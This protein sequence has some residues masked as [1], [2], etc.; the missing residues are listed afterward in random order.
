M[1]MFQSLTVLLSLADCVLAVWM[2]RTAWIALAVLESFFLFQLQIMRKAYRLPDL[3][4]LRAESEVLAAKYG[5]YFV[6][7]FAARDYSAASATLQ[8]GALLLAAI[9]WFTGVKLG[10][11]FALLTWIVMGYAAHSFSPVAVMAKHPEFKDAHDEI[12]TILQARNR[13]T[14]QETAVG[15]PSG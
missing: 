15:S 14:A 12:M 13:Q 1:M 8:F 4:T 7:P 2:P 3:A 11:A 5:H 10:V 9:T 6:L